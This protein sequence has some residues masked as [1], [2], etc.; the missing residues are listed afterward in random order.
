MK[1][2][3]GITVREWVRM[4]IGL[5]AIIAIALYVVEKGKGNG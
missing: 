1:T 3:L 4:G 2:F 5:L